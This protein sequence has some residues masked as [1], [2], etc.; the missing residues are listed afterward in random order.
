MRE[1]ENK[2]D[3]TVHASRPPTPGE[4]EELRH[5]APEKWQFNNLLIWQ[6]S[7]FQPEMS[8]AH[9]FLACAARCG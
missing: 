1:N 9:H 6:F 7:I 5:T 4:A 8:R 2:P 3:R